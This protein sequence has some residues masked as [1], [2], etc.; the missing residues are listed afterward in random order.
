MKADRCCGH[1]CEVLLKLHPPGLE[2]V[3]TLVHAGSA[4]SISDRVNQSIELSCH[5][6]QLALLGRKALKR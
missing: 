5:I 1:I 3:Q 6:G 2:F 4:Q